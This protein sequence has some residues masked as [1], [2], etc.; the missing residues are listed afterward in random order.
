M[1]PIR[2]ATTNTPFSLWRPRVNHA[3]DFPLAVLDPTTVDPEKDL[4][5]LDHISQVT[6]AETMYVKHNPNHRWYWLSNMT[7]DEAVLFTQHD[8]HPSGPRLNYGT[9][10]LDLFG[11]HCLSDWA[12]QASRIAPFATWRRAP[13]VL[14]GRASSCG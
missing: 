1:A 6:V 7:P 13:A 10:N 2:K 11:V 3:E 4:T 8:T 9:F 14:R 5:Y 12:S